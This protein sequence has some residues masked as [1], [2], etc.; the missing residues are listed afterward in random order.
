NTADGY[1]NN[2]DNCSDMSDSPDAVYKYTPTTDTTLSI[3]T[4]Y[5]GFDTKVYVFENTDETMIACNEDAGFYDYYYCGYY[6]SYLDSVTMTANNDYYIVVD[7]WGGDA[8]LYNLQVFARGDTNYTEGW[9]YDMVVTDPNHDP[10]QKALAVEEHLATIEINNNSSR[11]LTGYQVLRE[12]NSEWPVIATTSN[13]MYSDENLATGT[14]ES[15]SYRVKSV[16][17]GGLS[18]PTP[19]VTVTP[20]APITIPTPVNFTASANGWIINLEWEQ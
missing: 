14:D 20:F 10:E 5:S 19:T 4:C 13:T 18:D 9:D 16:Y 1:E 8:G 15:Y 2:Y 6:T 11:S 17:D 12:T 7:G 3:S